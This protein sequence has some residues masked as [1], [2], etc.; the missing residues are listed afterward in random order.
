MLLSPSSP[1]RWLAFSLPWPH[2]PHSHFL[3]VAPGPFS[4]LLGAF[5]ASSIA[6]SCLSPLQ[7]T[8]LFPNASV[9]ASFSCT[10]PCRRTVMEAT[11]HSV[12][13]TCLPR[14]SVAAFSPFFTLNASGVPG[15]SVQLWWVWLQDQRP[16]ST[17]ENSGFQPLPYW[18]LFIIFNPLTS[19]PKREGLSLFSSSSFFSLIFFFF[20][21]RVC[22]YEYQPFHQLVFPIKEAWIFILVYVDLSWINVLFPFTFLK[23]WKIVQALPWSPGTLGGTDL[24]LPE[25]EAL[26]RK[27]AGQVLWGTPAI[28]LKGFDALWPHFLTL[29][30]LCFSFC[31]CQKQ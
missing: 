21:K 20:I 28:F 13:C 22:G 15:Y 9:P 8:K 18:I 14:L 4:K 5:S 29:S 25:K 6:P 1:S 16:N 12:G 3:P 23:Q 17:S 7:L 26:P 10:G 30:L 27:E 2:S 24:V 11:A 31:W 19:C